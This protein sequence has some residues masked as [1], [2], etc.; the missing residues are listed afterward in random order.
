MN[1]NNL[2]TLDIDKMLLLA[3]VVMIHCNYS[4]LF[5][6]TVYDASPQLKAVHFIS[7]E[8]MCGA[9]PV[10]FILSGYLFFRNVKVFMP[11]VYVEKL[12]RR[13]HTLLIP[14]LLWN[15]FSAILLIIKAKYLNY[16][17]LGVV[18]DGEINWR[19]VLVGFVSVPG[20]A[21]Y[22]Y[23]FVMWFMR[24]LMAFVVLAPLA[25]LLSSRAWTFAIFALLYVAANVT[26][27]FRLYGFEWFVTGAFLS[28]YD[29]SHARIPG[30][31]AVVSL[32]LWLASAYY[33]LEYND[34]GLDALVR[35]VLVLSFFII[36]MKASQLL[37]PYGSTVA[38]SNLCSATFFIYCIHGKY[39]KSI[40]TFWASCLDVNTWEGS[41]LALFLSFVTVYGVSFLLWRLCKAVCPGFLAVITGNR[42]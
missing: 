13:V 27:G 23:N 14:Y 19:G 18:V 40:R 11:Q 28:R 6:D 37:E 38:V 1:T 8:L 17:G 9:V 16:D 7:S 5:G 20:N 3:C 10:F 33:I 29:I 35:T 32:L 26:G 24:N 4:M 39:C 36:T 34:P 25:R 42:S 41:M 22:P 12:R 21:A 15:L 2:R 31:P 30:W